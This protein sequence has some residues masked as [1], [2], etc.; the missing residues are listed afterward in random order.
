MT[1][2]KRLGENLSRKIDQL[3]LAARDIVSVV[4]I[5]RKLMNY[6]HPSLSPGKHFSSVL[7]RQQE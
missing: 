7:Q 6:G 5:Y 4:T 1:R 2:G 3:M